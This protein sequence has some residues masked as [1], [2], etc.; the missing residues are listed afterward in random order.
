MDLGLAGKVAFITAS[1]DGIGLLLRLCWQ[2]E[3]RWL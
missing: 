3:Q 1:S 2:R